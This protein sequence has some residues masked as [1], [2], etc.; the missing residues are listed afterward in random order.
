VKG[1]IDV[2]R[3]DRGREAVGHTVGYFHGFFQASDGDY[4][5]HRPK[6]SSCATRILDC[7]RR[8][9]SVR[10]TT[11]GVRAIGQAM[12]AGEKLGAFGLAIC[13]YSIT[14]L[15]CCSLMH[16]PY[17]FPGR[18]HCLLLAFWRGDQARSEF[19]V[20]RFVNGDATGRG[21]AL[22]GGAEAAQTAPSTARSR[23]ASSITMID[24][25]AAHFEAAMFEFGCAGFGDQATDSG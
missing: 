17:R 10:D 6:I 13:T 18:G 3:V 19:A 21:A 22:A 4:R 5:N 7:S 2:A 14:V 12:A 8:T 25:L 24:V 20:D 16:D 1:A 9:L 23:L 11:F 15:S